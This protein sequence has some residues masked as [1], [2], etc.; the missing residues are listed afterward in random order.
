M[1]AAILNSGFAYPAGR[2]LV[3]LSPADVRKAGPAFDLAIALALLAIDE[4]IDRHALREFIALG[5]L[6][7]DGTL[8][9]VSGILP[10]VL[11]ARNAGFTRLMFRPATRTK[12]RSST[13]SSSMGSIRCR[14]RSRSLCGHGAK[15]R[16]RS[17]SPR[18]DGGDE[19]VARRS[20]RRA[21]AS[22]SETCARDR[23]RRRP[24]S[25]AR[26]SAGL[27]QNDARAPPAVDPSGDDASTK[28][29]KS[30]RFTALPDCSSV[31]RRH[32][33]RAAVSLSA[34]YDQPDCA[35]RRRS[36][37]KAGRDLARAPRRALSRRTAGVLAQRDRSDAPAARRRHRHD[38]AR[39]GNVYVSRALSARRIDESMSVRLSRNAQRRVPLRRRGGRKIRRKLSGPLLD[40]IDLQI[41]IARVPFDDMVRC[42]GGERSAHDPRTSRCGTGAPKRA[43]STERP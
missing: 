38:R 9:P 8:Q 1:R 3:N 27:R 2:L 34:S 4:Q 10:M 42:D 40:R 29:S 43:A 21:R 11:G 19:I 17:A 28:R 12:P 16:R 14:R 18:F 13:A 25:S 22:C 6:A 31:D 33:P 24:Q 41:E 39:R 37:R 7:L 5:E 35:R 26:R 36:A 32:R 20:R 15:W 23:G 30:Q